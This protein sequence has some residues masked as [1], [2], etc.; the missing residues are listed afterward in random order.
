MK[1]VTVHHEIHDETGPSGTLLVT[2]SVTSLIYH[3]PLAIGHLAR[4]DGA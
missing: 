2:E 1:T 3:L 4:E